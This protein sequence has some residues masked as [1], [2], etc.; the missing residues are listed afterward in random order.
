[1]NTILDIRFEQLSA[2]ADYANYCDEHNILGNIIVNFNMFDILFLYGY[3]KIKEPIKA[4]R[5]DGITIPDG[6]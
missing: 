6:Y 4:F 5:I 2:R 1:M 3:L